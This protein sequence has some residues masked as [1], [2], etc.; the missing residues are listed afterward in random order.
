MNKTEINRQTYCKIIGNAEAVYI[1][2]GENLSKKY[3]KLFFISVLLTILFSHGIFAQISPGDLTTA[4]A[5]L[6]GLSNC[7]KCHE[8]GKRVVVSKCLDCHTEIKQLISEGIGYHSSSEVKNKKCWNCHSEHHGR[9]FQIIHFD[10]N[11][12]KHELTGFKLEGKHSKIKCSECHQTKFITNKLFVKRK[13][14]FL[15]LSTKCVS[16]HVDVHQNTLGRNCE[17]CHNSIKFKPAVFFNH[18]STK[19]KLTGAH[20]KVECIKC[21]V[22]EKLNG[23]IFQKFT[24]LEFANCTPCHK[25]VHKG[26]FGKNCSSCHNDNSFKILNRNSFDHDKTKFPLKGAHANVKCSSCHGNNLLSKPKFAKCT[27]CHKDAHFGEFT[28]NNVVRNCKD[29]HTAESFKV[30]IFTISDHNKIK[31]ELTGA[32]L[33]VSCQSCHFKEKVKQW[34]FK[35][36]GMKCIDCHKNVHGTEIKEKF[37]PENNCRS[38]HSTNDWKTISFNHDLTNFKLEGKHKSIKCSDCHESKTIDNKIKFKFVS[39]KSKCKTCHHDVHFG[40][41]D[42]EQKGNK[43]VCENCHGFD[44]WKPVNFDHEKTAFPLK[45]AHE[46][47]LCSSC[48]KK[49]TENGNEFIKYKLRDFKCASC[50]S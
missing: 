22:K 35:N 13:N 4:H 15:G 25:D 34:H 16:C 2:N 11:N 39:L 29:C 33:A 14:T 18:D 32:H 30:T 3:L 41:F 17:S 20:T 28:V 24:G 38:C 8:L 10:Q 43:P 12:F 40:Q 45:G 50:H 27:D 37:M 26:K 19:F 46:K 44:N 31:F 47:L 1:K 7:T 23:K 48:H 49:V 6:E 5:K 21:H 36:I 9:D 42:S